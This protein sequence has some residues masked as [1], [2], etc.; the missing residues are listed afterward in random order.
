[1][2]PE[3]AEWIDRE[4]AFPASMVDRITPVTSKP[5]D[6]WYATD[7]AS[8]TAGPSSANRSP[9]GLLS[10]DEFAAGRPPYDEVGVQMVDDVT[11]YELMKL[12]LLNASHQRCYFGYLCGY[13]LVRGR[14]G[15]AVPPISLGYMD[16][17]ATP[18]LPPVPGVDLRVGQ[19]CSSAFSN[20][21]IRD[22]IA[23]LCAESSTASRNG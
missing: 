14:P 6:P 17:E 18:T 15:P 11:P 20:P 12:R 21:E 13:R 7:S 2:D 19:P 10:E 3:L 22:T 9:N 1:M 5:T 23:R 8:R 4:V 16:E